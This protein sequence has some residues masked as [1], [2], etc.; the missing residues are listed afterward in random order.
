METTVFVGWGVEW[1]SL[2]NYIILLFCE[3]SVSGTDISCRV[4]EDFGRAI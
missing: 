1:K 4:R 2:N 3:S